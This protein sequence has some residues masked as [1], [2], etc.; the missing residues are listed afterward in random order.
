MNILLIPVLFMP[1][2]SILILVYFKS[3][4]DQA[5]DPEEKKIIKKKVTIALI[6]NI[7]VFVL[8]ALLIAL[9]VLWLFAL[10]NMT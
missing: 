3:Q 1:I 5:V 10:G 2:V 6:I 4:Y 9:F 8:L 7:I